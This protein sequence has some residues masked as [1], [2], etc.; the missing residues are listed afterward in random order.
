MRDKD[1]DLAGLYRFYLPS[2]A[3]LGRGAA[4]ALDPVESHH[5]LHVLRLKRGSA[6]E[7]FDGCGACASGTIASI[8]KGLVNVLIE[9]PPVCSPRPGPLVDLAFSLPKGKRLDWLLE[10]A[11]ELGAAAL[12]PVI[13]R[14][15]LAGQDELSDNK[16]HRWLAHCI[17]AAK[18]SG[19][20][21]LPD[22]DPPCELPVFLKSLAHADRPYQQMLVGMPGANIA[23]GATAS[24]FAACPYGAVLVGR[25]STLARAT[26]PDQSRVRT[27][28]PLAGTPGAMVLSS[29]RI[30]ILVGP[31]GG[32]ADDELSDI[33]ASGLAAVRLGHTTLR[34]ETAAIALLAAT[35]AMFDRTGH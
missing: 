10:K 12:L 1:P 8:D 31:E 11:A 2:L 13:C 5:A 34:I 27:D 19:T 33:K 29:A 17:A 16:R 7:L 30:L 25:A 14:R 4:A 3:G 24:P 18:Q 20:N 26:P 35:I 15:S 32:F 23:P 21:Y 22:I 28:T 6:V 9:Q